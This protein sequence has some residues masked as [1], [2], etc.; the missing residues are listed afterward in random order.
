MHRSDRHLERVVGE[1]HD[2]ELAPGRM[3]QRLRDRGRHRRQ[4]DLAHALRRTIARQNDRHDLRHL[5]D[6]Q[7]RIVEEV[8]LVGAAV[9]ERDPALERVGHR[10]A[11]AA[12]DLRLQR[13]RIDREAG[14]DRTDHALDRKPVADAPELDHLRDVGFEPAA[15]ADIAIVGDAAKRAGWRRRFP[16]RRLRRRIEHAQRPADRRTADGAD[17]RTGR[18]WRAGRAR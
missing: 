9:R 6:A 17:R 7:Q 2:V 5:V 4:H 13:V 12:L 16:V 15:A 14:I 1:R 10:K 18:S 3:Q 11:D 8:A